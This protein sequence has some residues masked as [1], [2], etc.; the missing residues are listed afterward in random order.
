M[1]SSINR[2]YITYHFAAS[3]GPS[4]G[5]RKYAEKNVVKIGPVVSNI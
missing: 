1:T 5:L 3:E 2:K 4:H